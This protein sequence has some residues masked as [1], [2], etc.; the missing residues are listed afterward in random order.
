MVTIPNGDYNLQKTITGRI[1]AD[2]TTPFVYTSPLDNMIQITNNIF[3]SDDAIRNEGSLLANDIA[4]GSE[5]LGTST[6]ALYSIKAENGEFAGF[7]RLGV[8]AD[9]KSW[10]ADLGAVEGTYG[11]IILAYYH[12]LAAPGQTAEQSR[13]RQYYFSSLD[14][15][16]NPY[17]F[18]SYFGQEKVF[19]ISDINNIEQIDVYFFQSGNFKDVDGNLIPYKAYDTITQKEEK[20]PNNLFVDNVS[21]M[22]GYAIDEFEGETLLLSTPDGLSYHYSDPKANT[23]NILLRWI[24]KIDDTHYEMLNG[25]NLPTGYEVRWFRHY[26]GYAPPE[27]QELDEFAGKDWEPLNQVYK[28]TEPLKSGY[29]S[30]NPCKL[31]FI[32]NTKKQNELVRAIGIITT[33][34]SEPTGEIDDAG[35]ERVEIKTQ[36]T[37]YNCKA[38]LKLE[39]EEY[40]PDTASVEAATALQIVCED[41]SEGNYFLYNQNGKIINEGEGQGKKRYFKALY[42]GLELDSSLGKLDFIEW[43]MPTEFTML[44]VPNEYYTE[45]SGVIN[46]D[47]HYHS[48]DYWST[49][50]KVRNKELT[51]TKMAYSIGNQWGHQKANNTIRCRASINGVVYEATAEL[52]F[53][54]SGTNGTNQT[55]LIEFE[56]NENGLTINDWPLAQQLQ[57]QQ[58]AFEALEAAKNDA[59]VT[60]AQLD[61]LQKIYN[62]NKLSQITVKA[63]LYDGNGSRIDFT[64]EQANTIQ[65]QWYKYTEIPGEEISTDAQYMILSN[66]LTGSSQTVTCRIN[67]IPSD[68]YYILQAKYGNLQTY[69]PIPLKTKQANFIEGAR[70]VIYNHQGNPNYYADPYVLYY[71]DDNDNY[72][73]AD[74]VWYLSQ[75]E[76]IDMSDIPEGMSAGVVDIN[77]KLNESYIPKLNKIESSGL[78]A[79]SASPMYAS[80][81]NDKICVY[82]NDNPLYGWS[83]PILIM[84]SRY[85]FAMLNQWDGTL[86]MDEENGSIMATML[87]AGRKNPDNTFSGVLI[88]DVAGGTDLEDT[89]KMTGVYGLH[90]GEFSFAL[91]ENGTAYFGKK[92]H[93]QIQIN[94]N[95]GIIQSAKYVSNKEGMLLDMDD[96][97]IHILG[98]KDGDTQSEILISPFGSNTTL[99]GEQ[100]IPASY[101]RI[102]SNHG[103]T[104]I[105]IMNNDYYLKSDN[106]D[107]HAGSYLDLSKGIF[108]VKSEAGEVYLS[109]GDITNEDS[110][111]F[112]I[113]VPRPS[114]ESEEDFV[115]YDN[116][117]FLLNNN[118]YYL[119]SQEYG[120]PS[121]KQAICSDDNK[122]YN[123]YLAT[124]IKNE[125]LSTDESTKVSTIEVEDENLLVALKGKNIYL[126]ESDSFVF[127]DGK[128]VEGHYEFNESNKLTNYGYNKTFKVNDDSPTGYSQVELTS[129]EVEQR[130]RKTFTLNYYP[131]VSDIIPETDDT[132]AYFLL[133]NNIQ[134]TS[135]PQGYVGTLEDYQQEYLSMVSASGFKLDLKNSRIEGYDLSMRGISADGKGSFTLDSGAAEIPFTI[136]NN[137]KVSWDGTLNCNK[138]NSLNN[139]GNT[140]KVISVNNNFYVSKSGGAGGSGCVFRGSFGG[141]CSGTGSFK[142][143]ACSGDPGTIDGAFTVTDVAAAAS[144]NVRRV[145]AGGGGGSNEGSDTVASVST[146]A[147]IKAAVN[148]LLQKVN[149]IQTSME[150]LKTNCHKH[151]DSL[152]VIDHINGIDTRVSSE[153]TDLVYWKSVSVAGTPVS[154]IVT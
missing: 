48:V 103:N 126:I 104:L 38:N 109:G 55:F 91:K 50:R 116:H 3:D 72:Q 65:W 73:K 76:E 5:V 152:S 71:I 51:S 67:T 53:G 89:E 151:N 7:T 84:Q 95:T 70:E 125:K 24:H 90:Q 106:A 36:V 129:L 128:A 101:F 140:E 69:L 147:E 1:A 37:H 145:D 75:D 113:S 26:P 148:E 123:T 81:F 61:E 20:L 77:K 82:T 4:T 12:D 41:G 86:K 6:T 80:G 14:M 30:S 131:T 34:T 105:N 59:S 25:N 68:N 78:Y 94:G 87:G 63:R 130:F 132:P 150:T 44:V 45:N 88:G 118:N 47:L 42:Q 112:R 124:R 133:D 79:L 102:N 9:F 10:L 2:D 33:A 99:L 117:L 136:G 138:I 62:D 135:V 100:Q 49:T 35:N 21:I 28:V 19:D 39:N 149:S 23:K 111:Y 119:K 56:N 29:N 74:T 17:Y 27:G 31:T 16:G 43:W 58:E 142:S 114:E 32:P 57:K 54:K 141:Y 13:V 139:D 40:V 93:G 11:I 120:N 137:F 83:Q 60:P 98:E 143:I 154:V 96:G 92:G 22:L 153:A 127:E 46:K 144:Y 107:E 85:D 18:D 64:T 110:E 66:T 146:L 108:N 97:I 115:V 52:R 122:K 8:S 15:I 121:V 134:V